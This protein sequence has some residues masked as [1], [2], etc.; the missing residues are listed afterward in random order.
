MNGPYSGDPR[1]LDDGE[2]VRMRRRLN[3]HLRDHHIDCGLRCDTYVSMWLAL[4][5]A[6]ETI[7]EK[8]P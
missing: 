7:E 4:A 8:R 3:D 5:A 1:P 2:A 6:G